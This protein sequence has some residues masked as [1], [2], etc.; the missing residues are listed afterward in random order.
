MTVTVKCFASIRDQIGFDE[1]QININPDMTVEDVLV[2]VCDG[3]D[4]P[5]NIMVAV[6][7]EY[8]GMDTLVHAN[9]ELAFFPPVTGG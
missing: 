2:S 4:V 8:A 5:Y 9:D 3:K 7:H 1:K 6:N